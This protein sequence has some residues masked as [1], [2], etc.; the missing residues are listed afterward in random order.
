M[1]GQAVTSVCREE[2]DQVLPFDRANLDI[3]NAGQVQQVLGENQPDFVINCAAWTDVDGCES[4]P[5]RAE[6][7]NAFGPENLARAT[8]SIGAGLITISTDYVFDGR[9]EGFYTQRDDPNPLGVYAHSKLAGERR[10]QLAYARTIVVRSGFIFGPGGR[11]F[12][13][14]FLSIAQSGKRLQAIYDSSGTPTYALDLAKRIRGLASIDLPGIYHVVNAGGGATYQEI[15][16]AGLA[17]AGL[18]A[19]VESVSMDSLNRPALRPRNSCLSC[20]LSEKIGLKPLP[21]WRD[22]MSHFARSQQ[23]AEVTRAS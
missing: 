9:K 15:V 19:S 20:L 18:E 3:A 11:N 6:A 23:Q 21:M 7:A 5:S 13:S 22:A 14:K 16:E 17:D 2:G 8:R 10:A 4:D 12:L 1:V